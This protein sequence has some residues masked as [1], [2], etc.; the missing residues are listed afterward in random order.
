MAWYD[1]RGFASAIVGIP[2][3]RLWVVPT[4]EL[5]GSLAAAIVLVGVSTFAIRPRRPY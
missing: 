1:A 3:E 4:R 5:A 2:G